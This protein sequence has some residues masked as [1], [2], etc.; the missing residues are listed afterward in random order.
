MSDFFKMMWRKGFKI[1]LV[2]VLVW[3]FF[4]LINFFFPNFF[5]FLKTKNSLPGQTIE[6][7]ETIPLRFR[8]YNLFFRGSLQN[9]LKINTSTTSSTTEEI[10]EYKNKKKAPYIWGGDASTTLRDKNRLNAED[11]YVYANKSNSI[12]QD[13]KIDGVLV[14]EK[15]VNNF[16][17]DSIVTGNISTTYLSSYYF[18]VYIYDSNGDYLYQMLGN[19][20][21]DI[22]DNN[23]LNI[24]SINNK[25][26]DLSDPRY[27]G[28]G[29]MVIWS[30]NPEVESILITKIKIN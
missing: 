27:T 6:Q 1:L 20:Y 22:K 15:G 3:I 4:F 26:N 21:K 18:I 11:L 23:I 10:A 29:F 13:F 30:D 17:Q 12:A 16:T 2:V 19:G 7:K 5:S 9:P 14:K 28:D 8:I 24:T 25:N